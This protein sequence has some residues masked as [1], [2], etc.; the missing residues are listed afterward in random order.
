MSAAP[1][2]IESVWSGVGYLLLFLVP[3]LCV[4]P[5]LRAIALAQ[6]GLQVAKPAQA[7][8]AAPISAPAQ[9]L[10]PSPDPSPA[11]LKPKLKTAPTPTT[12]SQDNNDDD[13]DDD[14]DNVMDPTEWIL[15]E[16]RSKVN[17]GEPLDDDFVMKV[18]TVLKIDAD[19]VKEAYGK[20][21]LEGEEEDGDDDTGPR[22]KL[23]PV[24]PSTVPASSAPTDDP[25]RFSSQPLDTNWVKDLL[26]DGQES[27][28]INNI[29]KAEGLR[30]ANGKALDYSEFEESHV[31]LCL[32]TFKEPSSPEDKRIEA[33][34]TLSCITETTEPS[35]SSLGR[36]EKH[37]NQVKLLN[38]IIQ[39]DGL[40][41]IH[42]IQAG[43]TEKRHRILAAHVLAKI[44]SKIYEGW[45]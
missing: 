4:S 10:A 38:A 40:A 41:A 35:N 28:L 25:P 33:L 37:A 2:L 27:A 7:S 5:A 12:A 34:V 3:I 16:L 13:D 14:D 22:S 23:P 1:G 45:N 20:L 36:R 24:D 29:H 8:A 9:S 15:H 31:V 18:A 30:D 44:A 39:N 42:D 43:F 6:L 32:N 19:M 21:E 11:N 17:R 26:P